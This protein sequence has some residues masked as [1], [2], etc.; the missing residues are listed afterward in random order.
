MTLFELFA[1]LCIGD[2]TLTS[3]TTFL[4][5]IA[6]FRYLKTIKNKSCK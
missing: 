6:I 5:V 1:L 4:L 2:V 3:F